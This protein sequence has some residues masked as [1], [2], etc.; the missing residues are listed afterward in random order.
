MNTVKIEVSEAMACAIRM[1]ANA[2]RKRAKG[3]AVKS[4][5]EALEVVLRAE[6]GFAETYEAMG[7]SWPRKTE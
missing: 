5:E 7:L 4:A 6:K 2:I 3:E 1:R